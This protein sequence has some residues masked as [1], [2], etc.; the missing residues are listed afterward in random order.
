[1]AQYPLLKLRQSQTEAEPVTDVNIIP[2]IDISLVL[3]VILFV[4]APLLSYPNWPIH[5]PGTRSAASSEDSIAVT[6]TREGR[7]SV[8]AEETDWAGLNQALRAEIEKHPEA[9]V[10]LRVD[11][12]VTY[13]FVQR[14]LKA[15]KAAGAKRMAMATEPRQ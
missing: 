6:Y 13:R 11:R 7:L 4:T 15:A 9:A 12:S 5:L 3:L 2:V 10:L 1:M 14:L 8:R